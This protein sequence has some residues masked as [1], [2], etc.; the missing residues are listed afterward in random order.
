MNTSNVITITCMKCDEQEKLRKN[1]NELTIPQKDKLELLKRTFCKDATDDEFELFQMICQKT[2]LDP[3]SKQIYAI[4]RKGVM[5]FQT[6]IDGYRL[7]AERTGR[8]APGREPCFAYDKDGH[9]ISATSFIKKQTKDG[10]WHEVA[11]TAFYSEYVVKYNGKPT[12]F[13]LKMGHT[14]IAKCAEALALRKSFPDVFSGIYT[15]DEMDQ[16]SNE[17]VSQ[18]A[19]DTLNDI[20]QVEYKNKEPEPEVANVNPVYITYDQG[21]YLA[22]LLATCSQE[23]QDTVW[24]FLTD[25]AK[26]TCYEEMRIAVYEK[27]LERTKDELAKG[28]KNA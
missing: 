24:K 28:D 11:A 6:S 20:P 15:K 8:Y 10:S 27:V 16:A 12:D 5:T 4:K 26:V 22:S 14:M 3:T 2:G 19:K 25:I 7:I 13:W 23:Y 1:M 17:D 9:L 18:N 21:K